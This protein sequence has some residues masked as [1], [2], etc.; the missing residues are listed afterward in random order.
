MI[1]QKSGATGGSIDDNNTTLSVVGFAGGAIPV[2]YGYPITENWSVGLTGKLLMAEVGA[3]VFRVFDEELEDDLE[4]ELEEVLDETQSTTTFGVDVGAMYRIPNFQ[5]GIAG[6]NLNSPEFD[7]PEI[8]FDR[9][10]NGNP[11]SETRRIDNITLEP[12]VT[13]GAAWIPTKAITLTVEADMLEADAPIGN[14]KEQYIRGGV[15]LDLALLALRA[16]AYINNAESDA[17]P[18]ITAGLG[19]N[20]WLMRID[21]AGAV[22][23]ATVTYDGEDIPT[24]ARVSLGIAMDF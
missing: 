7:G 19:L 17:D 4:G 10:V 14:Y 13:V 5:F 2:T 22:S 15:E 8:T 11:V 20:L 1:F 12:Q 21:L 16:G 23:T 9:I 3:R 18:V 6:K 24:A